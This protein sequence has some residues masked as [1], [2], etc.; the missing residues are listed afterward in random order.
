MP[1]SPKGDNRKIAEK[2]AFI[3]CDSYISLAIK[4][5]REDVERILRYR[6]SIGVIKGGLYNRMPDKARTGS[7]ICNLNSEGKCD[8]Y[9]VNAHEY[10]W[11]L[12]FLERGEIDKCREI[13]DDNERYAM[14]K[15]FYMIERYKVSNEWFAPWMPN[16]SANGR[17]ILMMLDFAK[18]YDSADKSPNM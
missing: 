4:M 11:F 14:S 18:H 2:F 7:T 10:Y 1:Y 13:I 6:R 12:Y 3:A 15:E 9:Y 17:T 8:V 16:A 5:D